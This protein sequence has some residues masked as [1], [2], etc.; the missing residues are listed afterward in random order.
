[1][2]FIRTELKFGDVLWP[3]LHTVPDKKFKIMAINEKP[4]VLDAIP[5][6]SSS[7]LFRDL[8]F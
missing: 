1:M 4:K 6:E 5:Y 3:S 2:Y 8:G 7:Q